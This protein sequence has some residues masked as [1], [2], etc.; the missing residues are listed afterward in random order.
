VVFDVL[1]AMAI[2]SAIILALIAGDSLLATVFRKFPNLQDW[3]ED[4]VFDCTK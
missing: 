3:L 2:I 1:Y 4:V